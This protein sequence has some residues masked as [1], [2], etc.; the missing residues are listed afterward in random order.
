MRPRRLQFGFGA[1]VGLTVV[2]V[3]TCLI[4]ANAAAA[5]TDVYCTNTAA[6]Q[7]LL[8]GAIDGGGVVSIHGHCLGNWTIGGPVTL[9]GAGG[10]VLDGGHVDRVLDVEAGVTT[11][12][13]SLVIEHGDILNVANPDRGGGISAEQG[14]TLVVTDSTILDNAAF[15]GGGIAGWF[16]SV[17]LSHTTI[18]RNSGI[19]G[20][21]V[22]V[23]GP[24]L[25]VSSSTIANNSAI[26]DGGGIFSLGSEATLVGSRVSWNT[27]Q[28]SGGGLFADN[29]TG[30]GMTLA[31][32]SVDHNTATGGGG[33]AHAAVTVDSR[34]VL[35]GSTV[36]F[37]RDV[38]GGIFAGGGI[39]NYARFSLTSSVDA[40]DSTFVGNLAPFGVGGAIDN[41]SAY[42]TA[43]VTLQNTTISS[44][45]GFLNPNRARYGAGVYNTGGP[46][47][48]VGLGAILRLELGGN[49]LHNVALV[50]GG[51][52]FNTDGAT[53][54]FAG[55][56]VLFN[57]PDN[58]V[59][60]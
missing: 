53:V 33:I 3:L 55:G 39:W 20:G 54:V 56:T 57:S 11:T 8:Q 15:E 24:T 36:A 7:S 34:L 52:V 35:N 50:D 29:E 23:A 45:V 59:G 30:P 32:T 25:A 43:I 31:G 27:A 6:D 22:Y 38:A 13:N 58:C 60:C 2:F 18:S 40:S 12:V 48:D 26:G 16:A 10:A 41:Q 17:T 44:G 46:L 4:G 37:N 28:D 21:G 14:S 19:E 42:G 9:S 49:V 5:A 1:T 51:G 47:D